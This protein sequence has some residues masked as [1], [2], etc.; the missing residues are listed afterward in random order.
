MV[1]RT[2]KSFGSVLDF[3]GCRSFLSGIWDHDHNLDTVLNSNGHLIQILKVKKQPCLVL[4]NPD[5]E[6]QR[7]MKATDRALES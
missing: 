4:F 2:S 7:M 1:Q 6:L 3:E 5:M